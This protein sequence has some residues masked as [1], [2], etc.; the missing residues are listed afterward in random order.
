V[1]IVVFGA[2][3]FV[4]G[5]ICEEA[6]ARGDID[7]VACVRKWASSVRLARR[8]ISI[9]Q[10]DLDGTSALDQLVQGADVVVNASMPP[11]EREAELAAHLY[12]SCAA[13]GVRRF[14]QFSSVAVYGSRTGEVSEEMPPTP[15]NDYARGKAEME[16]RLTQEAEKGGP[17][18]IILR[19]SIIY[20]PFSDSW[21]VRFANR[22]AKSHWRTLGP[23]GTGTCNLVYAQDV[24]RAV[25][26]A[27]TSDVPTGSQVFNITSDVLT[28]NDYLER[29]GDALGIPDRFAPNPALF[30]AIALSIGPVRTGGRWAMARFND[31]VMHFYQSGGPARSVM[32]GAESLIKLYPSLPEMKLL[33]LKANYSG[34]RAARELN[35]RPTMSL[36]EGLRQSARWCRTHGVI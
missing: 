33:R 21:T 19:P 3:G 14:I 29:F 35:F 18:L 22:I 15:D 8:G 10:A 13:A 4:G 32:K 24:A 6:L 30:Y 23:V 7:L 12:L 11:P 26:V 9:S 5:W 1:R 31:L 25:L 20:G 17:Q 27:A 36:E 16:K 34:A 2:G 28:W